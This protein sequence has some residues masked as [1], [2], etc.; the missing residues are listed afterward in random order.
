[1]LKTLLKK[2][3]LEI[4]RS[5]FYDARKGRNR[6]K[7]GAILYIAFYALLMVGYLGGLFGFLAHSIVFPFVSAGLG[8]LYFLIMGGIA[9]ILGIFGSVFSTYS[10]L[11]MAKDNDLLLSMPIPIRYILVSRL[12]GVFLTGLM[13]SAVVLIPTMIM[14]YIAAPFSLRTL[15]GPIVF[16]IDMVLLVFILSVALGWVVAKISSRMKNKSLMTTVV[17]LL[18]LALYYVIYFKAFNTIRDFIA[19]IASTEINITGGIVPLYHL[20]SAGCGAPLQMIV[21]TAAVVLVLVLVYLLLS[22]TFIKIVTTKTGVAKIK[23]KEGKAKQRGTGKALLMKELKRITSSS[24]ILLN[25]VLG[26][27]ILVFA[28]G[29]LLVK[30]GDFYYVLTDAFGPMIFDIIPAFAAGLICTMSSMCDITAFSI[31]LEGKNLWILKTLPVSSKQILRAKKL[32]NLIFQF[33]PCLLMLVSLTITMHIRAVD[34]LL[35][36][37]SLCILSLLQTDFGLF[38]DLKRTNLNWTSETAVV[39]QSLNVFLALVAGWL[40][41][42]L[43]ILAA[44]FLAPSIGATTVLG[45]AIALFGILL[46][47]LEL[48]LGKR[49]AAEFDSL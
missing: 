41:A 4:F 44:L 26:S 45:I 49:G 15:L 48:W 36:L 32:S 21:V 24:T 23:Y 12:L 46:L 29:F 33:P 6:T 38:L 18:A 27:I 3:M 39:K 40:E 25:C 11:Y 22:K 9:L 16:S 10:S 7:K 13:Y 14:Y 35:L 5:F 43:L 19:N 34:I 1:M 28:A 42:G 17:A 37:V 20:G 31:S 2:Q 30:G 47:I 8:W